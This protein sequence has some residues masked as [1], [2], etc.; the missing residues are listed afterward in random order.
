MPRKA[1]MTRRKSDRI[2]AVSTYIYTFKIAHDGIPPSIRNIADVLGESTS[3]VSKA[4]RLAENYGL[5]IKENIEGQEST[6]RSIRL[7]GEKYI[8]PENFMERL[9]EALDK[10]NL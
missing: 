5:L 9:D 6:S 3:Q 4:I 1:V 2:K 8:P 10:E 7:P